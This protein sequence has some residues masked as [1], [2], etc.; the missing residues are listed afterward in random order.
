MS[1]ASEEFGTIDLG[2]RRL[3]RRAVRLVQALADAPTESI[4]NACGSWA[5]TQAAY[6]LLDHADIGW[7]QVLAPHFEA[8]AAR[9]RA[10]PVVLCTDDTIELDFR[11]KTI[12]GLGSLSG[13]PVPE[14]VPPLNEVVRLVAASGGFLMRKGDGEPGAKTLWLGIG[15]VRAFVQGR[16]CERQLAAGP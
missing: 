14:K 4:P 6:R 3:D 11:G 13:K 12:T 8:T 2:D 5:D 1:W 10:R 7:E 15:K 9:M 16:R